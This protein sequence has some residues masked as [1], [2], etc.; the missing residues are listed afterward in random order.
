MTMKTIISLGNFAKKENY[1]FN[2]RLGYQYL[3][4]YLHKKCSPKDA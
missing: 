2:R 3:I 4:S 1:N